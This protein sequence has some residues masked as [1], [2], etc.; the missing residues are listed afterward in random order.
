MPNDLR[1][2]PQTAEVPCTVPVPDAEP[3]FNLT[4]THP[5]HRNETDL[6]STKAKA[7]LLGTTLGAIGIVI[8]V[9]RQQTTDKA[10]RH[11]PPLSSQYTS[12]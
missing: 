9:H 8:F 11:L 12:L 3:Q 2:L 10:V 5:S 6:M 4:L 1:N 7:T